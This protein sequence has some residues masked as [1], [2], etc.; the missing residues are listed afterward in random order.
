[1]GLPVTVMRAVGDVVDDLR[2]MLD[3]DELV[4]WPPDVFAVTGVLLSQSGA[5]RLPISPPLGRQWPPRKN[6]NQEMRRLGDAWARVARLDPRQPQPAIPI[7]ISD[8]CRRLAA[9]RTLPVADVDDD[10]DVAVDLLMLHAAADEACRD[11]GV[12][13]RVPTF[14][15]AANLHLTANGTLSRLAVDRL[16]V[17]PK[18]RTPTGGITVRSLSRYLAL[19]NAELATTWHAVPQRYEAISTRIR[20]RV[21]LVPWPRVIYPRD[22]PRLERK[23]W[24]LVN[25]DRSR[26]GFFGFEPQERFDAERVGALVDVAKKRVGGVEAVVLPELA[27]TPVDVATLETVLFDRNVDYLI[28]GVRAQGFGTLGRNFVHLG[29]AGSQSGWQTFEQDKHHR[30]CLDEEQIHQYHLGSALHPKILWR[31]AI[32]IPPR[33]RV[34]VVAN[35]WLTLCP[36]ICEDLARIDP[37]ADSLHAVGPSL[38]VALLLD[39]PQLAARW[40]GRYASALAD[41]PGSSVLTL[42]SLG[43]AL[44]ARPEGM[45]PSRTIGLWKDPSR[46]TR[47]IELD[48][49]AEAALLT[50]SVELRTSVTA[51]GRDDG[52]TTPEL[53]LSG[54]E[55]IATEA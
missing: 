51:D 28:A 7:E 4:V 32:E 49:H 24:P 46:G 5:F 27:L 15:L 45:K 11:I 29:V 41:D 6:W 2:G 9:A 48:Q 38:V 42:T 50:L 10:W 23:R 13:G 34:F 20:F 43:M 35:Q 26:F 3:W 19:L 18:M 1:M 22:F 25:M 55:Q 44:R 33:S 47:H 12:G 36:V 53:V 16:R 21:L 14:T 17:L 40:P 52:R 31:E 37:V 54:I 8:A 30:W 39:G